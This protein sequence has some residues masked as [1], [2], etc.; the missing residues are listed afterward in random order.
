M[1]AKTLESIGAKVTSVRVEYNRKIGDGDFGSIGA[2]MAAEVNILE[3]SDPDAISKALYDYCRGVVGEGMKPD[4]EAAKKPKQAAPIPQPPDDEPQDAPVG[5]PE[6]VRVPVDDAGEELVVLP[7]TS[8]AHVL[9]Q[10][11][12]HICK[13]FGK[14][15]DHNWE[16]FGVTCWPEVLEA[17][18]LKCWEA[19][20]V[21]KGSRDGYSKDD[22]FK[23]PGG[24]TKAVIQMGKNSKGKAVPQKVIRFE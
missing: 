11:Q 8:I 22:R 6:P 14:T 7:V 5:L 21:C 13:V 20:P 2:S 15:A 24:Y 9:T 4:V 17:S 12:D 23:V 1:D 3:G 10:N 19:W 16:V 18:G